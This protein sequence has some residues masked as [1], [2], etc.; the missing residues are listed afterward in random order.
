MVLLVQRVCNLPGFVF[1]TN[2]IDNIEM[3]EGDHGLKTEWWYLN[4]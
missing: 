1:T 4:Y 2:S 3:G